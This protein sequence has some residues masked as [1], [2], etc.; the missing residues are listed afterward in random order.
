MGLNFAKD[1][2]LLLT[3]NA[4]AVSEI[5]YTGESMMSAESSQFTTDTAVVTNDKLAAAA[6]QLTMNYFPVVPLLP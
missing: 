1:T 5:E 6:S 4:T 2:G 3:Q